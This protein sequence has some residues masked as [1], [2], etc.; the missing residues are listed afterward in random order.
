M[1]LRH[2]LER[3]LAP[4]VAADGDALPPVRGQAHRLNETFDPQLPE[5]VIIAGVDIEQRFIATRL[6][7]RSQ[8]VV[9]MPHDQI[10]DVLELLHL[11]E[12][13]QTGAVISG[14]DVLQPDAGRNQIR[15][16]QF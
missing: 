6:G 1:K 9:V 13:R 2:A 12:M 15:A 4:G 14:P 3:R 8:N 7:Q 16:D 10:D 5:N 11:L